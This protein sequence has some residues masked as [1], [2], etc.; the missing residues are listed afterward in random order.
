MTTDFPQSSCADPEDKHRLSIEMA[1]QAIE[2]QITAITDW[3][4]CPLRDAL[5][6]VL[7]ENIVSPLAVPAHANS[8]MDGYAFRHTDLQTG[9]HDTQL[10]MVGEA[11]AGK[12][13]TG[14]TIQAGQCVRV[15]T[16]AILPTGCDSIIM[17]EQ[18]SAHQQNIR[19]ASS[20]PLG[21][22]V[23][24]AGEDIQL[25]DT[26]LVTG[27]R[28]TPADI[29]LLAS[30]GV[31][32]VAVKRRLKVA[33]FSTGDELRS[34]GQTLALGQIYDSNRYTISSMLARLDV[35]CYDMGV[36][37]D[38]PEALRRTMKAASQQADVVI[39]SG[40]VSVGEADYVKTI[41]SELGRIGFWKIAMRPGRPL[42]FGQIDNALF[43][44]LPG[45]PVSVMVTFYQFV[46]PA[47]RRLIGEIAMPPLT[48]QVR[49]TDPIRKRPG[50]FEYQRGI[51]AT[52]ETGNTIVRVTGQQ[53]SGILRSMSSADCFILL[54]ER[55]DGLPANSL[56]TVQPFMG[57][58]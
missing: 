35:S 51:L 55:C 42:A 17:Q 37:A 57:L 26:I 2:Q 40:G 44:G 28:L 54:D 39:T 27:R 19:F 58:I 34:I 56:V 38:D 20:P 4:Y 15:M 45:N 53:G 25:G 32:E 41:L 13:Y 6:R 30:L 50:R 49:C 8:A 1:R 23:R 36:V 7:A 46:A 9:N 14:K 3:H 47:L 52:D 5:N 31:A 33:F 29:G 16:G 18:V 43:F 22:H 10:T 48:M 12:P 24:Y 21:E 11:F